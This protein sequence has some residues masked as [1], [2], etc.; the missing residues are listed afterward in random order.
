MARL[1]CVLDVGHGG[2][3]QD[4]GAVNEALGV[5]EFDFNDQLAQ[6]IKESYQGEVDIVI[7]HRR[8]YESLPGD[9][10]A[11]SPDFIVSLHCNSSENPSAHGTEV[12]HWHTSMK[13]KKIAAIFQDNLVAALKTRDRG[14]KPKTDQD[15]GAKLLR[16][17]HSP[18]I[19]VET[20]F[21]SN[22][23]EY[24]K[25]MSHYDELV[26]AFTTSINQTADY[27]KSL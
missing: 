20:F 17:T 4:P 7:S 12:L 18:C 8:T 25:V 16:D 10:N 2:I 14:I 19:I 9:L 11:L 5:R 26:A 13:G 3:S 1:K 15:R 22:S 6:K 27:L 23:E 21:L 24:Q